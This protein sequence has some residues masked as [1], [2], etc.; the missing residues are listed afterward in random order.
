MNYFITGGTGFVGRHLSEFLLQDGHRVTAVGTS[1]NPRMIENPGFRYIAADLTQPGA[2]QQELAGQQVVINLAG[3]SIFKRWTEKY[4]QQI[5]DSRILTTRNLVRA[6]PTDPDLVFCSSSA[7]GYYGSRDDDILME[8]ALPGDDFLAVLAKN[9][10]KEAL[11]AQARGIRV[12]LTRFGIVLSRDGGALAKMIPAFRGFVGGPLGSGSQWFSWIHL[13]D[14]LY[15]FKF[16]IANRKLSGPVNFTA[17]KPV[18]N[19]ALAKQL[20]E[21]LNRPAFM[22]APAFMLKLILGEFGGT[23]LASQR[24]IPAK[25]QRQGYRFSYPDLKSAL[26]E[27]IAS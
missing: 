10:E 4:K 25:L 18:R 22:P 27:I 5:Y 8:D 16:V 15:A 17:P 26:S 20:G 3:R 13:H 14:L 1:R 2:W 24:A 19:R 7:V 6:L 9:W 12:V 23:L 21:A 11:K